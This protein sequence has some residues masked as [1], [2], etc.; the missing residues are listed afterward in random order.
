MVKK[1]KKLVKFFSGYKKEIVLGPAFKLIE[2]LF[3]LFVP[4]VVA[5]IVDSAIKT[6]DK[7]SAV[8][9]LFYGER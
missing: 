7:K 4:I 1:V 8:M 3:E 2:A 5:Y 9:L 6:Q